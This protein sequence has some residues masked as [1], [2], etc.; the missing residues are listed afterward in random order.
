MR[1]FIINI[2]VEHLAAGHPVTVMCSTIDQVRIA[3]DRIY[4]ELCELGVEMEPTDGSLRLKNGAFVQ[5]GQL[6]HYTGQSYLHTPLLVLVSP[7]EANQ[8]LVPE[9]RAIACKFP[10][11]KAPIVIEC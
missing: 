4:V 2:V 9:A 3:K 7:R 8:V 5:F 10:D 1:G 6:Q 11:G